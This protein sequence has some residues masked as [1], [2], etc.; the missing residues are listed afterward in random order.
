MMLV[1]NNGSALAMTPIFDDGVVAGAAN[2]AAIGGAANTI[3]AATPLGGG[4]ALIHIPEGAQAN[5][6][7]AQG[8]APFG[9]G[10]AESAAGSYPD[11]DSG[12][13]VVADAANAAAPYSL[14]RPTARCLWD[15]RRT[16]Q[17]RA[18]QPRRLRR[19]RQ[20]KRRR[21]R[22]L[23]R[24]RRCRQRRQ[25]PRLRQPRQPRPH[26]RIRNRTRKERKPR[27]VV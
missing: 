2:D 25:T 16:A 12:P 17:T 24:P 26:R 8:I 23:R 18:V 13:S 21:L 1:N 11:A 19:L 15:S 9:M 5:D 27:L 20:R 3:D 14:R 22:Q 10:N 6:L 7:G 4:Y